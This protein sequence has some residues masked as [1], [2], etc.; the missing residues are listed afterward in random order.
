M[1]EVRCP[2]CGAPSSF[3]YPP[4]RLIGSQ[5]STASRYVASICAIALFLAICYLVDGALFL[6]SAAILAVVAARIAIFAM[7]RRL[8]RLNPL[9]S[10]R[11][12]RQQAKSTRVESG[13]LCA[14]CNVVGDGGW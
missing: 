5:L 14:T 6:V 11:G 3:D 10:G 1:L 8:S 2:H 4:P 13:A 12:G 7:S 9:P